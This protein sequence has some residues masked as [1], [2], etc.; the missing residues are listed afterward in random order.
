MP[1]HSLD[2]WTPFRRVLS[3]LAESFSRNCT[4]S[5][6]AAAQFCSSVRPDIFGGVKL[7]PSGIHTSRTALA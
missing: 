6:T 7:S 2:Y 3:L 1:F 5:S 4:N